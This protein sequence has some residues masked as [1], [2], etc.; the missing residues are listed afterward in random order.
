MQASLFNPPTLL[1]SSPFSD[2]PP[3]VKTIT[4]RRNSAP[5][6][7]KRDHEDNNNKGRMVDENMIVLRMRIHDIKLSEKNEE[8]P[9]HWME[10][11]KQYYRERYMLDVCE[12]IGFLQNL[13]MESRPSLA[14]GILALF[15]L[16][17]S[18]SVFM[19]ALQL[20]NMAQ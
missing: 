17:V 5:M 12:G 15:M 19:V 13:L 4:Y 11:E 6:A 10:W 14:L 18:H 20:M 8:L 7:V 3:R 2:K 1:P 16:C 9:M